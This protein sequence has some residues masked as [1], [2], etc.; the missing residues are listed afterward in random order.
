MSI[1]VFYCSHFSRKVSRYLE[2]RS[3]SVFWI[4]RDINCC[5]RILFLELAVT[6]SILVLYPFDDLEFWDISSL[7]IT[8]VTLSIE[9]RF[10]HSKSKKKA[11]KVLNQIARV[12]GKPTIEIDEL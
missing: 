5:D 4:W 7:R 1:H 2:Y 6:L 3:S 8:K 9:L 11:I 12:N 10:L